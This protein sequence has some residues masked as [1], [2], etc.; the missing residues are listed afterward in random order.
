MPATAKALTATKKAIQQ[1]KKPGKRPSVPTTIL[2]PSAVSSE[3]IVAI[4]RGMTAKQ[5]ELARILANDDYNPSQTAAYR[6]VYD[7]ELD[8]TAAAMYVQ[9]HQAATHPKVTILK[10]AIRG[11]ARR[12]TLA[13]WNSREDCRLRLANRLMEIADHAPDPRTK[14]AALKLVGEHVAVRAFA[15]AEPD[16][17]RQA[18]NDIVAELLKRFTTTGAIDVQATPAE[19][20]E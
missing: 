18:A 8:A 16:S 12:Q 17:Q 15:Q 19:I 20:E 2:A 10:E 14:L 3:E 11:E 7:T 9:A 5:I 4:E 1:P 13:R 6:Q